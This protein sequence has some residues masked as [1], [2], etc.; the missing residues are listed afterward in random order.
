MTSGPTDQ[1]ELT[2]EE[3]QKQAKKRVDDKIGL[4][5]HIAA[6]VIIN[7]FIFFVWGITSNWDWGNPWFIWVLLGWGVGLAFNIFYYFSGR[8][9]QA[10]KD[11][12]MAKEMDR[13]RK[14][15]DK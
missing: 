12:M 15:Q 5:S 9:G 10:A 4:L 13:I 7:T 14:E 6:Y 2:E 1:M 8:K 11:R 3:I